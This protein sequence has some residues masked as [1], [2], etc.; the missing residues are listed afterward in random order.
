[1]RWC[2]IIEKGSFWCIPPSEQSLVAGV[3]GI[4]LENLMCT[5]F[6]HGRNG[7][8]NKT[9]CLMARKTKT[10]YTVL[11]HKLNL[12]CFADVRSYMIAVQIFYPKTTLPHMPVENSAE[13]AK[14]T[15][16]SIRNKSQQPWT[17]NCR[18]HGRGCPNPFRPILNRSE[19]DRL[20]VG[21]KL[22]TWNVT[23]STSTSKAKWLRKEQQVQWKWS[24]SKIKVN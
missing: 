15:R 13:L 2:L 7:C 18:G 22:D 3:I 6:S 14:I 24:R 4:L 5:Y 20:E 11:V 12:K 9:L 21:V 8:K 10:S 16:T 19:C 1:M 17:F 23:C